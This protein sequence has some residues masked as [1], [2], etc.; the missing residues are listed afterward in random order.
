MHNRLRIRRHI[1]VCIWANV[2]NTVRHFRLFLFCFRFLCFTGPLF[3]QSLEEWEDGAVSPANRWYTEGGCA[4]RTGAFLTKPVTKNPEK[5][6]PEPFE[7]KGEI[8][9]EPLVWDDC[10][11]VVEK[12]TPKERYLH[13]L[14]LFDGKPF[15]KQFKKPLL[16]RSSVP[17]AP[18]I[19]EKEIVYRSAPNKL[20]VSTITSLRL[21]HRSTVQVKGSISPPL[22]FQG[23]IYVHTGSE[24]QRLK[25]GQSTP[26]WRRP[27]QFRGQI[28]IKGGVVYAL[29][30]GEEGD[31]WVLAVNRSN[32]SVQGKNKAGRHNGGIPPVNADAKIIV[33][34]KDLY[35]AHAIPVE[36]GSWI[37]Y[38][39]EN[40]VRGVQLFLPFG[41]EGTDC[42]PWNLLTAAYTPCN[43][44]LVA[45]N[46]G[47]SGTVMWFGVRE[48]IETRVQVKTAAQ[49]LASQ[50]YHTHLVQNPIP[51]AV[52]GQ[53]AYVGDT[54]FDLA[55]KKIHW[56][57]LFETDRRVIPARETLLVV[58]GGNK[59][60]AYRSLGK[61]DNRADSWNGVKGDLDG[62]AVNGRVILRDGSI[63][64]GTFEFHPSKDESLFHMEKKE[65]FLLKEVLLLEEEKK[66]PVYWGNKEDAVRA[67]EILIQEESARRYLDAAKESCK[68][69]APELTAELL[70]KA[71]Q[72]GA[73][74]GEMEKIEKK[75]NFLSR[76]SRPPRRDK[77]TI[78]KLTEEKKKIPSHALS[79]AWIR[80]KATPEDAP[81]PFRFALFRKILEVDGKHEETVSAIRALIPKGLQPTEPF[82]PFD[83][84]DFIQAAKETEIDYVT[85]ATEHRWLSILKRTWRQDVVGIK[86][87]R[88]LV[89]T[90]VAQPGS[91][92]RCLSMGEL[93]CNTLEELF[94]QF[95]KRRSGERKLSIILYGSQQEYLTQSGQGG[96]Y[97][98]HL[99]W[100]AGHY[101]PAEGVSR[102]FIPAH[103]AEFEQ[104]I[105]VFAHEL[106]HQWMEEAC[107]ALS[108]AERNQMKPDL[109]GF[110]I[111]EGLA[112]L[113]E[114]FQFDPAGRTYNSLDP[115]CLSLDIL[116][117]AAP[118]QLLPWEQVFSLSIMQFHQNLDLR[119]E[120]RKIP[121]TW[122]LGGLRDVS[123]VDLF[124]MQA[125]GA[126]QYLFHAE[127]GK[128]RPKLLEYAV[129]YYS[130]ND[131][132]MDFQGFFGISP[133]EFGKKV[134]A[135]AKNVS[136]S[137][138]GG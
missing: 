77:E 56:K 15:F 92:A 94:S 114:E 130:G 67:L 9:G 100:T 93:V 62:G 45:E 125:A 103:D 121:S 71:R 18:C 69:E 74:D 55:S 115:R 133:A 5:V 40:S 60:V 7:V 128:Y 63:V 76:L 6:W 119:R 50:D 59:L 112:K 123:Q 16:V 96:G 22:F 17:L 42:V 107:P 101:S 110:W 98:G 91:V 34:K 90:P 26:L 127:G 84:L 78:E 54:A 132:A 99:A 47:E 3:S 134:L 12:R 126:C 37:D 39:E 43:Q 136:H 102:M 65:T 138:K 20:T 13:V 14:R 116:S 53:M 32:G 29:A 117:N 137:G 31:A 83:W 106:T 70:G 124:Y 64:E 25:L 41:N 81:L 2:K 21:A 89:I 73:P 129:A 10:I 80:V 95:E 72:L 58:E 28:S 44:W 48:L 52:S 46:V 82:Q 79:E 23:E 24:L 1:E 8:E 36:R 38:G 131:D 57:G 85:E 35:V 61:Q 19:W 51:A 105:N 122:I 111:V 4:S 120:N 87:K 104:I 75:L 135:Y 30:Y 66:R 113:I 86:S 97:I 49:L 109:P 11:V 68:A 27:G 88:L 108:E 33:G 118:N